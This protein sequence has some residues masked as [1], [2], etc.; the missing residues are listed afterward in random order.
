MTKTTAVDKLL[1]VLSPRY[2]IAKLERM[3]VDLT[4]Q[5]QQV[6]ETCWVSPTS[7]Q[8]NTCGG[9]NKPTELKIGNS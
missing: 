1:P 3:G 9:K 4:I 8:T 2:V 6:F 7:P 5:I